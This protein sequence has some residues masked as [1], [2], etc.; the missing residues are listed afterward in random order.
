MLCLCRI[1]GFS[2]QPFCAHAT[3]LRAVSAFKT[4][5]LLLA[6]RLTSAQT[7]AVAI[8]ILATFAASMV[9]FFGDL[10]SRQGLYVILL[11]FSPPVLLAFERANIDLTVVALLGLSSIALGK[12]RFRSVGLAA[13]M[14]VIV[15]GESGRFAACLHRCNVLSFAGLPLY[16]TYRASRG[17]RVRHFRQPYGDAPSVPPGTQRH[18][19]P[20]VEKERIAAMEALFSGAQ[21]ADVPAASRAVMIN[22]RGSEHT[23]RG[24]GFQGPRLLVLHYVSFEFLPALGPARAIEGSIGR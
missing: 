2:K 13:I 16:I 11:L 19:F 24:M 23:R 21:A 4:F 22:A 1:G 12:A 20:H 5:Y 14:P 8:V 6:T 3:I 18:I 17:D 7:T 15:A 9:F 10:S